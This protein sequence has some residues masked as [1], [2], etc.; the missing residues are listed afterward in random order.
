MLH[1]SVLT[2]DAVNTSL[3]NL[4]LAANMVDAGPAMGRA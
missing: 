4:Q 2:E 3:G 1:G